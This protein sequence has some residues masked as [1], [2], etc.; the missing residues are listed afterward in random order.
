M[1]TLLHVAW[2]TRWLH[3]RTRTVLNAVVFPSR[4]CGASDKAGTTR[5]QDVCKVSANMK[6]PPGVQGRDSGWWGAQRTLR[7]VSYR[8]KGSK[9]LGCSHTGEMPPFPS[10]WHGI[11]QSMNNASLPPH[12]HTHKIQYIVEHFLLFAPLF[13]HFICCHEQWVTNFL[14]WP[15]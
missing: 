15:C 11:S 5:G 7:T 10:D 6:D 2:R 9:T 4:K 12:T 8:C 1:S 3:S 14:N 13:K